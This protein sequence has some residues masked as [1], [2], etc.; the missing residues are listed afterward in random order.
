MSYVSAF[1]RPAIRLP[2][3]ERDV[4]AGTSRSDSKFTLIAAFTLPPKTAQSQWMGEQM[5]DDLAILGVL[6]LELWS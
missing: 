2:R 4:P 1:A 6:Q 3:Q 5:D